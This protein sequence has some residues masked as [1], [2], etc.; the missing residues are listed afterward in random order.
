MCKYTIYTSECG[1]PDE[2]HVDTQNCPYFQK[3]QV[4]CDRDNPHI[5][6]RV[7]IRTKDRNGICNRCLRDARMREE[8]AMRREREKMEEQNQSIAEHKRKMAEM[9]AREQEIKRQTKEDHDRQV[10]GRE[11]ADRQ[12]KLNKALEEQAL[13]AQQK[14][15]DM[16]RALRES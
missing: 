2:D 6:D 10:R 9:E 7:K 8:A 11:E 4:P 3:T 5:K 13:R 14:A 15:D 1:H 12:F 16:E